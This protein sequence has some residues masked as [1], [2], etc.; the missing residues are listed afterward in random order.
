[1]VSL[2]YSITPDDYIHFYT[3]MMWDG[4]QNAGKRKKYYLRQ[5]IGPIVF[6]LMFYYT[7]LLNRD[8]TF[9]IIILV[10]L[11]LTT[12][13]SIR[14]MR[15]NVQKQAERIAED[16]GNESI[17]R[18]NRLQASETGIWLQSN[19]TE[20]RYQW[21]AFTKRMDNPEYYFLFTSNIQAIIIPKRV[22][23]DLDQRNRFD[24]LLSQH[25][26]LDAEVGHLVKS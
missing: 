25:L 17:F 5:L 12:A 9:I 11:I 4:P 21:N 24:K 18:E 7:G 23:T 1:M 3:Y 14:N 6:L 19:D 26:S 13:L 2:T 16:P 8:S 20:V 10:F 15:S 22:F